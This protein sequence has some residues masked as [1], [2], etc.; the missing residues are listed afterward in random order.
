MRAAAGV[1]SA[2]GPPLQGGGEG[3]QNVENH[4][5]SGRGAPAPQ[6]ASRRRRGPGWRAFTWVILVV[7]VLLLVEFIGTVA[8]A[9]S[10]HTMQCSE[11][12]GIRQC[13]ATSGDATRTGTV[14]I[15]VILWVVVDVILGTI[16]LVTRGRDCPVCG[17]KVRRGVIVCGS[18]GYDF[19]AHA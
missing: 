19:R 18:C 2:N 7:N 12:L 16:W 3:T 9:V 4:P 13:F 10:D 14:V 5:A 15:V 11:L 17:R 6:P 8:V 1:A